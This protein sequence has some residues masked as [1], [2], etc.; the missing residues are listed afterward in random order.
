[1]ALQ[2]EEE[3]LRITQTSG[4]SKKKTTEGRGNENKKKK[5]ERDDKEETKKNKIR[6]EDKMKIGDREKPPILD[7]EKRR[8]AGD[9]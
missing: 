9:I 8:T 1:M 7:E 3:E 6:G 5:T 2:H 4:D